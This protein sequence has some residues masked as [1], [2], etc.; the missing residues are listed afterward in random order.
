[1]GKK[2]LSRFDAI[3][4]IGE[5]ML[6]DGFIDVDFFVCGSIRRGLQ[7]VGDADIIIVGDYPTSGPAE[8]YKENNGR[9]ARTYNYKGMQINFWRTEPDLLGAALL[10][11]T[12]SGAFNRKLRSMCMS[13]G[14]K[15]S[16]NGLVDRS[17]NRLLV[18][19]TEKAIFNYLGLKYIPPK[20]RR[21]TN[22]N[23][24]FNAFRKRESVDHSFVKPFLGRVKK[25]SIYSKAQRE[26]L[27][28]DYPNVVDVSETLTLA[29]ML[30]GEDRDA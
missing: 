7:D 20:M 6:L 9:K 10:Y 28:V 14:L 18:G 13:K 21:K 24:V 11:A 27:P 23:P 1:M 16:Q 29:Q 4:L 15:L 3:N 25:K 8:K 30:L 12:G 5:F 2:S 17:T 22:L 19:G 26:F